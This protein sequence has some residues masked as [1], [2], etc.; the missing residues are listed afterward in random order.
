[1]EFVCQTLGILIR[2][3]LHRL[4]SKFEQKQII[5][6]LDVN[7]VYLVQSFYDLNPSEEQVCI[8]LA[9]ILIST[10]LVFLWL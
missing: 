9:D 3:D 10:I 6:Q 2:S 4:R 1:M 8:P 5:L 7:D